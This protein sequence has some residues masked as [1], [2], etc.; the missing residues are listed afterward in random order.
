MPMWHRVSKYPTA[1]AFDASAAPAVHA[2][3]GDIV[4]FETSDD[5]HERRWR[6]ETVDVKTINAI[7]GSVFVQGAEPGDALRIDILDIRL[8]DRA[9]AV[10]RPG[11]GPLSDRTDRMQVR[12]IPIRDGWA[13]ISDRLQ[14]PVAPMIGC[15]GVAPAGDPGS[16][17]EP[18]YPCGGNMDLC[19][20][21]P[22]ATLFLPVQVSGAL[23]ALGG[24]H[25]AMGSGEPTWIALE[26][27]G[28]ATVRLRVEK[29]LRLESPRLRVPGA[30]I[31]VVALGVDGKLEDAQDRA[32]QQ[33]HTF[34]MHECGLDP[35]EAFAYCCARVGSRLG[36]P[37]SPIM[38]AVVPD[39]KVDPAEPR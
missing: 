5:G 33:A 12:K 8:N 29:G 34:L 28:E 16:T 30:T 18:A 20:V 17:Y 7:T 4:T 22:G 13:V 24:I 19:E 9:W 31:F 25:A 32:M 15:I 6:G 11:F 38:L 36:G 35:F 39:I 1:F 10:W 26:A 14:V 3:H 2:A 27:A 21:S 23:L 37:A